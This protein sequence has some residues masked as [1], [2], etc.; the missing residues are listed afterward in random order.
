[1]K[2][3]TQHLKDHLTKR[4]ELSSLKVLLIATLFFV[5]TQNLVFWRGTFKLLSFN[6]F[7]DYYF[8]ALL[9]VVLFCA[10][11]I[12][13]SLTLWS[14]L[15]YPILILLILI[16]SAF[17]YFSFRY[18]IFMDRDMLTNIIETNSTE[19]VDLLSIQ[20]LGWMMITGIIPIWFLTRMKIT[21]LGFMKSSFQRIL[22][23][24]L[25]LIILAGIA[26]GFYKDF[27]SFVRNNREVVKLIMPSSFIAS[28][29][30]YA[31]QNYTQNMPYQ[32]VGEDATFIPKKGGK[33]QLM[34]IVVGETAR[35]QNFSLNGYE[36]ETNPLLKQQENL[37]SF[38]DIQSCGTATAISV[39]C[40]FSRLTRAEFDKKVAEKQDNA[41][42]IIQR[43]GY[44]V[45]W[46]ENDNGCKG[47]CARV[48]TEE[49][50]EYSQEKPMM[51]GLYF[52]EE[53]LI[54]LEDYIEEQ[55]SDNLVIVLHMNGSHGPTYYQRYP[56]AFKKF[57]PSCDTNRIETCDTEHLVNTYD[58]TILYTDFVLNSTIELLKQ[59]DA[60]YDTSML[61]ISD[62]GES[63][64]EKNMYLHGAPYMI[65]PVE[66]TSV[67]MIFWANPSFY[68]TQNIQFDGMQKVAD[69][70]TYSHDNIFHTLLGL[71]SVNT[72]SYD[73]KL[74][75][76]KDC[77]IGIQE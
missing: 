13:F 15:T 32:T 17:N 55:T 36:K 8:V 33:K 76:F 44:K 25:S 41:L 19:I 7:H 2:Y 12:F 72:L 18:K 53:L 74:N 39:P 3:L 11:L 43:A 56:D 51:N 1:M 21:P 26:F 31:K 20:M 46:R 59:Y 54:G 60:E 49:V 24:S 65:A 30:S 77:S 22:L 71:S 69:Q 42:D 5:L 66:Q 68:Q 52:D 14:R 29:I 28:S 67:P 9:F 70:D 48:T 16:S 47:V 62:H 64:G 75:I 50:R 38:K 4:Y 6:T 45:L 58:N 23:I 35:S 37:L 57:T 40:M 63:L 34:V 61:Y 27:A 10:I 73:A